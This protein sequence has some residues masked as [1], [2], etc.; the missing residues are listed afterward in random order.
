MDRMG[1][2]QKRRSRRD[3]RSWMLRLTEEGRRLLDS[4]TPVARNMDS[5]LLQALPPAA[6]RE[7]EQSPPPKER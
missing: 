4:A 2:L 1:L 3:A 7:L 5:A 6:L